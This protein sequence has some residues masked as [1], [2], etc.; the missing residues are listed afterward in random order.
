[1]G[2]EENFGVLNSSSPAKGQFFLPQHFGEERRS[3]GQRRMIMDGKGHNIYE[4]C[5]DSRQFSFFSHGIYMSG[6]AEDLGVSKDQA[7]GLIVEST[8]NPRVSKDL[9]MSTIPGARRVGAFLL[10]RLLSCA[11]FRACAVGSS[12]RFITSRF[13]AFD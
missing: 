9:P 2:N 6:P 10:S 3:D 11:R 5:M 7:S 1:M 8:T 12:H 4:S 13:R